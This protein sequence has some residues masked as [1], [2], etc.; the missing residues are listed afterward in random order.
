MSDA[1]KS[2]IKD[3]PLRQP[4][5]S[6]EEE[7]RALWSDKMEPY[8]LQAVM[9]VAL[10]FLEWWRFYTNMRPSPLIF[11]AVAALAVA[12]GIWQFFKVRPRMRALLQ[13]IEGEKAVGQYLERLRETGYDVFHDI[14][15]PGF[16]ID[17]VLI[18]PAGVLTIETKTWSKPLKGDARI[19]FDGEKLIAGSFSPDRD[20][21][22][23]ARAQAT[24]LRS[25]LADSTGKT[26][27]V[28]PVV[29]FPGW[30]IEKPPNVRSDVWVLEPKALPAFLGGE[31]S[32]LDAQDSK[33]AAFHLSRFIRSIERQNDSRLA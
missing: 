6:L 23:Q 24:W 10:A 15:A 3:K 31:P 21:I 25:V 4:A 29:L 8:L 9:L 33:L 18:G 17:H 19:M 28:R 1:R 16:N 13:G 20:P 14:V 12:F 5:Q 22:N 2:P 27:K 11:T 32:T 30:F 7:R 26:Y